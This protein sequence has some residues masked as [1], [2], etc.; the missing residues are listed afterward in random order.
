M[1]SIQDTAFARFE[2]EERLYYPVNKEATRKAGRF[3]FRGMLA[4]I[5]AEKV[6]DEKK[7]PLLA[8]DQV[9]ATAKA[10]EKAMEFFACWLLS[11]EHLKPLVEVLGDAVDA[12]GKYFIF[13]DNIDLLSKYQISMGGATFYIL[14]VEGSMV[15]N[16]MLELL[17]IDKGD[18]K[19]LDAVGKLDFVADAAIKFK[20]TFPTITFEE[21][22][23]KMGPVRDLAADRPV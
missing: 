8:A 14:P 21:G 9:I 13:C 18:L 17:D 12:N 19:K 7:P 15:F 20:K 3:G 23:Q 1:T 5:P 6:A 22:L 4:V 11:F 16:E 10:G 2:A